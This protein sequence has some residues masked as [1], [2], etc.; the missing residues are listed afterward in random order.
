ME[1]GANTAIDHIFQ[2]STIEHAHVVL[3]LEALDLEQRHTL[4]HRFVPHIHHVVHPWDGLGCVAYNERVHLRAQTDKFDN[5]I[6]LDLVLE[7]AHF[8]GVKFRISTS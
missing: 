8:S 2:G 3:V 7:V 4:C 6:A 5:R 1:F